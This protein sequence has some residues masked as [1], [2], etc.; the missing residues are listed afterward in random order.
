[1]QTI[2]TGKTATLKVEREVPFG[3]FLTNEEQDVLLHESE[4]TEPIEIGQEIDVFIY[5]DKQD[6]L[7]ASMK[8]PQVQIDQYDWA[9]V[10]E[11]RRGLG[12]FVDIGINK[13]I[14]VSERDLPELKHLWPQEGDQLYICLRSN[15]EGR[16]SGRLATETIIQELAS[17]AP[18]SLMNKQIKGRTYR[19]L[20]VGSFVFTEIGFRCFIHHSEQLKE[21][22]LGQMIEGRVIDVKEDG[23]LN[24]SL[25][26]RSHEK[27][28]K[29]S[30][31]ILRYL[32]SKNGSMPFSDKSDPIDIKEQFQMSK[33]S[34]KRAL[35]KLMK[36]GIIYQE[37]GWT[38][39]KEND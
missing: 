35:G 34:F 12:V 29:D 8:I 22:R 33:G 10:V 6:R 31:T 19:V 2:E 36:E 9:S 37:Q 17:R 16:L 28:D 24:V 7:T 32:H 1:M 30:E 13:D 20:R 23:S 4:I 25:I 11:V 14:L 18:E 21:P 27:M 39:K 5:V 26:P 3:Y 15:Q 38:H